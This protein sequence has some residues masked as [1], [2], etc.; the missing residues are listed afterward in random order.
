MTEDEFRYKIVYLSKK[1]CVELRELYSGDEH[2]KMLDFCSIDIVKIE[3]TRYADII[4]GNRVVISIWNINEENLDDNLMT[5]LALREAVAV[6]HETDLTDSK[7]KKFIADLKKNNSCIIEMM[8]KMAKRLVSEEMRAVRKELQGMIDKCD[9]DLIMAF[10][11]IPSYKEVLPALR[12]IS[13]RLIDA[14]G[15]ENRTG[16]LKYFQD[17]R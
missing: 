1:H 3:F 10:K 17:F 6:F 7:G 13:K 8:A 5:G 2:F 16:M 12:E 4:N 15:E 14:W 11:E 9:G